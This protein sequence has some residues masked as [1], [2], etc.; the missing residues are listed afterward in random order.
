M[1]QLKDIAAG[2]KVNFVR[3]GFDANTEQTRF[4]C[5]INHQSF[6]FSCGLLACIPE[7]VAVPGLGWIS[8]LNR[9][10]RQYKFRTND[11]SER[12]LQLIRQGRLSAIANLERPHVMRVFNDISMLCQPTAYDLLSCLRLDSEA[13]N[14]SFSNWCANF[15]YD[16]DSIKALNTYNACVE[17]ARKLK[18]ALG[19]DLYRDVMESEDE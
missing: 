19:C 16:N 1:K 13:A 8:P 15:G 6:D 17:T 2:I 7:K 10:E 3:T 5:I 18:V 12:V 14:E 9:L 4:V 11:N